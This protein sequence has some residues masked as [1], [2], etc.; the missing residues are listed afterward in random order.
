MLADRPRRPAREAPHPALAGLQQIV[1]TVQQHCLDVFAALH[2]TLPA[3]DRRTFPA[4]RP[5]ADAVFARRFASASSPCQPDSD[6][7][8]QFAHRSGRRFGAGGKTSFSSCRN[9]RSIAA[10]GPM[11]PC[12]PGLAGRCVLAC[13]HHLIPGHRASAHRRQALRRTS[14]AVLMATRKIQA[15]RF[16]MSP[17]FSRDRQHLRNAS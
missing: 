16:W 4:L 9:S 1:K 15:H 14:L 11:L 2:A 6:E 13:K 7:S 10:I 12:A 3:D 17:M 5:G 8:P